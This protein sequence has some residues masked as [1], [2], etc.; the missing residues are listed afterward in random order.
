MTMPLQQNDPE[1]TFWDHLEVLRWMLVRVAGVI[2]VVTIGVFMAMP[3]LFDRY[4]LA[5]TTSQFFMYGWLEDISGGLFTF[6]DDFS[7]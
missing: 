4:I 6:S 2:E 5:P 1:L 3:Y 7:V